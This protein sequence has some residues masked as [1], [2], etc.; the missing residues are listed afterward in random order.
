VSPSVPFPRRPATR[1]TVRFSVHDRHRHSALQVELLRR[2]RRAGVAGATVWEGDE[3]FGSS[4]HLHRAH[5]ATDD[6]PIAVVFVDRAEVIDALLVEIGPV[7]EP[8]AAMV[9]VEDVEIVEL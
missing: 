9:T 5:F 3:G 4:G 6:R 1:L 7:L 2:A 8:T